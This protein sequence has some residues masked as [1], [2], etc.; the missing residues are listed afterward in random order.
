MVTKSEFKS[1][2]AESLNTHLVE[3]NKSEEKRQNKKERE[4][5]LKSKELIQSIKDNKEELKNL[6]NAVDKNGKKVN[7]M[8]KRENQIKAQELENKIK[9]DEETKAALDQSQITASEGKLLLDKQNEATQKMKEQLEA[10]GFVA[11]DTLEFQKLQAR[12]TLESLELQL[13]NP[14]LSP[15]KRKELRKEKIAQEAILMNTFQGVAKRISDGFQKIGELKVPGLGISL[16]ALAKLALIPLFIKFLDSPVWEKIKAFL[17]DPTWT[18][19]GNIIGEYPVLISSLIAIVTGYGLKKIVDGFLLAKDAF[20][21]LSTFATTTLPNAVRGAYGGAKGFVINSLQFTKDRFTK[22]KVFLTTTLPTAIKNSYG[23]AKGFLFKSVTALAA[24]FTALKVFLV[25]SLIPVIAG[26]AAPFLIPLAIVT[27]VVAGAVAAFYSIKKGIEDFKASLDEGDSLLDAIVDGVTKA[28]GTLVTLPITLV[29][30]F[31]AYLAEK[32]GFEGI[33]KTLREFDI[34][35]MVTEGLRKVFDFFKGLLDIDVMKV[36]ESIPGA[37][38]V[39][40]ALGIVD[41]TEAEK[42][43]ELKAEITRLDADIKEQAAMLAQGDRRTALGFSRQNILDEALIA[44][45]ELQKQLA[46]L[47]LYTGGGLPAGKIALVGEQGPELVVTS[48][49]AQVFSE[50]RTDQIGA[51]AVNRLMGGGGGGAGTTVIQQVSNNVNNTNR[52]S[53][54]R[55]LSDQDPVLQRLSS[56]LAF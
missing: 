48:S 2:F 55:P 33:A 31:A 56:S 10:Q 17:K 32:L 45:E 53:V 39:L 37:S 41:K 4:D 40:K 51:A 22:M 9:D 6:K 25:S 13:K 20:T 38:R 19:F 42:A 49:P 15:A 26:I 36:V 34:A 30:D 43:D 24:A 1:A 18:N 16:G 21:A 52:T 5:S 35:S 29:K 8:R 47:E 44:K 12:N 27:A 46:D 3:I 7:D 14:D 54:I 11:E 50:Q 23:G 28:L